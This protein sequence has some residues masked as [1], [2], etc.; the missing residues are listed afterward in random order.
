MRLILEEYGPELLYVQHEKI[1]VDDALSRLP[2][3][4]NNTDSDIS[5][6]YYT[7]DHF[8]L[9]DSDLSE[10]IY[11]LHYQSIQNW[12]THI[13][14]ETNIMADALNRLPIA[15]SETETDVSDQLLLFFL[16]LITYLS[17]TQW[18]NG[19]D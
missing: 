13:K 12:Y 1:L 15:T 4:I 5:D 11:P 9:E 17:M 6:L 2:I 18:S 8:G 19:W 14:S 10:D 7:A 3:A 16:L